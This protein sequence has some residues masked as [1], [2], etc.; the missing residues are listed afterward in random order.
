MW[1]V[2][3]RD[4]KAPQ[5]TINTLEYE[6]TWVLEEF[7][8]HQQGEEGHTG[9]IAVGISKIDVMQRRTSSVCRWQDT[10]QTQA[11]LEGGRETAAMSGE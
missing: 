1:G 7:A 9:V 5:H 10:S 4:A 2:A 6:A 3:S 11:Y 8:L